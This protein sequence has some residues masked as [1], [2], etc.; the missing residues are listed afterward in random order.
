MVKPASKSPQIPERQVGTLR[1]ILFRYII[2]EYSQF[3]WNRPMY[4]AS[5]TY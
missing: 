4:M 5:R 1:T 2:D 3:K